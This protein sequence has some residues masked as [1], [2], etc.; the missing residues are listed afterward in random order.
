MSRIFNKNMLFQEKRDERHDYPALPLAYGR[1]QL[2]PELPKQH[3]SEGLRTCNYI[4][5]RQ[6]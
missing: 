4:I 3:G 2:S 1:S 6:I 5:Y